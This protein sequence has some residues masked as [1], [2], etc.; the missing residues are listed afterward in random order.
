MVLPLSVTDTALSV[1]DKASADRKRDESTSYIGTGAARQSKTS[2]KSPPTHRR[3][4][5]SKGCADWT[6]GVSTGRRRA[7]GGSAG[8]RGLTCRLRG[9][10]LPRRGGRP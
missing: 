1:Q 3:V 9:A 5:P 10:R 2:C 6:L 7:G 8:T 4:R